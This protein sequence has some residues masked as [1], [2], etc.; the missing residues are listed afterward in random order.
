MPHKSSKL[1]QVY[2]PAL[3]LSGAVPRRKPRCIASGVFTGR[4]RKRVA[5]HLTIRGT[6]YNCS[7]LLS[8]VHKQQRHLV[9]KGQP[10]R[11][12]TTGTVFLVR[13]PRFTRKTR[14]KIER[15]ARQLEAIL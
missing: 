7:L 3:T 2:L 11:V 6:D 10:F 4:G 9:K 1:P 5:C 8:S 15:Y 12:F 14:L 13:L